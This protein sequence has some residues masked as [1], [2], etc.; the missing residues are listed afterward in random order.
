MREEFY[1]RGLSERVWKNH[2]TSEYVGTQELFRD[3]ELSNKIGVITIAT[4]DI[5]NDGNLSIKN[6]ICTITTANG[7]FKYSYV[8]TNDIPVQIS[9]LN[10]GGN[11]TPGTITRSYEKPINPDDCF[12]VRKVVY[13]P[14]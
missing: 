3:K 8:K 11:F 1:Y 13:Q 7:W 6:V 14:F 10:V 2:T 5:I 4:A 12:T 9:T